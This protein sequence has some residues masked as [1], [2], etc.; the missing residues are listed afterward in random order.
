M[1][2]A[3]AL[4]ISPQWSWKEAAG[5][6]VGEPVPLESPPR[7]PADDSCSHLYAGAPR[8][9][10]LLPSGPPALPGQQWGHNECI[11]MR[12]GHFQVQEKRRELHM[13]GPWAFAAFPIAQYL[14][15]AEHPSIMQPLTCP[16]KAS[17]PPACPCVPPHPHT[18]RQDCIPAHTSLVAWTPT[19]RWSPGCHR[20]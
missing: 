18:G 1:Q 19:C 6:G 3:S 7:R 11:K 4:R 16:R 20:A 9:P 5:W 15:F 8:L 10:R 13:G 17:K 2:R 14:N 12:S